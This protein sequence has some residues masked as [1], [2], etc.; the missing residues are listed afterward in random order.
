MYFKIIDFSSFFILDIFKN[1]LTKFQILDK[2]LFLI[3]VFSLSISVMSVNAEEFDYKFI[4]SKTRTISYNLTN[5][6]LLDITQNSY[7]NFT[8][9]VNG[10]N[11]LLYVSL[12]KT[13][14][15]LDSQ[16]VPSF[17]ILNGQEIT[18]PPDD[19]KCSYDFQVP[20]TGNTKLEFIFAY[21]PERPLPLYYLDLPVDCNMQYDK[22]TM[23]IK[24]KTC[25]N[26]KSRKFLNNQDEVVC[27]YNYHIQQ[28][29]DRG[30]LQPTEYFIIEK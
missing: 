5:V 23:E 6:T 19:S 13:I 9:E 2:K 27:V 16:S 28:L 10:I 21:W 1:S 30:Y 12:P 3:I 17:V 8:F 7:E 14:P 24:S 26:E 29:L 20:V 15:I 4:D 18:Y 11:G 25:S 22:T